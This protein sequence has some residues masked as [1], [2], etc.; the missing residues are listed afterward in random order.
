MVRTSPASTST[1]CVRI[2]ASCP[3]NLFCSA[4]ASVTTSAWVSLMPQMSRSFK[5]PKTPMPTTL[6]LA[7][8]R[9]VTS[10]TMCCVQS[11]TTAACHEPCTCIKAQLC[12]SV[13]FPLLGSV[14][15]AHTHT[16]TVKGEL[17][18]L[19]DFCVLNLKAFGT[20]HV[21]KMTCRMH[22]LLTLGVSTL[23]ILFHVAL[24]VVPLPSVSHV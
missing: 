19:F 2:L 14:I 23:Q 12:I 17:M 7:C 5:L 15:S 16:Q 10:T 4:V 6:Y 22:F 11:V 1:G 3:R 20:K 24:P 8:R 18:W 21:N 9:L 13:H